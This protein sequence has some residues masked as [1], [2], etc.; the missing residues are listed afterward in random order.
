MASTYIIGA[1]KIRETEKAIQLET[2]TQK[3]W[4]PKS[5]I[6]SITD[7]DGTFY[8]LPLWFV[9]KN[10]IVVDRGIDEAVRVAHGF[11]L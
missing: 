11:D 9:I 7:D 2:R 1:D 3:F 6:S 8:I 10:Q 5:L 4:V